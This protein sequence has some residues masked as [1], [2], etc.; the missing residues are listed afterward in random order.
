MCVFCCLFLSFCTFVF[1]LFFLRV[2]IHT[3][4]LY[5][6]KVLTK[7]RRFRDEH[8]LP[9]TFHLHSFSHSAVFTSL[10]VFCV[11]SFLSVL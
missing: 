11:S 2:H 4:T 5:R 3:R 6:E 9:F 8:S 1:F 7:I 10:S